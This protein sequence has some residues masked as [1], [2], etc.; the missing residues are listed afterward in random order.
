MSDLAPTIEFKAGP[1]RMAR[2]LVCAT[3]PLIWVGGL[4][5]TYDAGMAVPDWP[6]TYGYNL[7]LYPWQTWIA[8]PWDL[9]IEHGHRLLGSLVGFIA[10]GLLFVVWRKDDRGWMKWLAFAALLLVIVQGVLG[11]QRVLRDDRRIAQIHGVVGP[12]FFALSCMIATFTSKWWRSGNG[13]GESGTASRG[14]VAASW[15]TSFLA[16]F[17]LVIGSQLRHGIEYSSGQVFRAAVLF[18]VLLAVILVLQIFYLAIRVLRGSQVSRLRRPAWALLLL[19]ASQFMLG[20][21]S[22]TVK[23][24]WPAILQKWIASPVSTVQAKS[25]SQSLIVTGHVAVGALILATSAML[26]VRVSRVAVKSRK[27]VGRKSHE[28]M[29][30]PVGVPA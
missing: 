24:G 6:S 18:H 16:A 8:G 17:Q 20:I 9:F 19:V 27:T 1:N 7:F 14:L 26:A 10:I 5:T 23:Y 4:V 30:S 22:W 21:A 28:V 12:L 29:T 25:M 3:F 11:G 2:L 13:G 15:L